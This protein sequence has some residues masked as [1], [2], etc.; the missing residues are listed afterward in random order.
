MN[1]RFMA[2]Q[3]RCATLAQQNQGLITIDSAADVSGFVGSA[4]RRRIAAMI[5]G[6][7]K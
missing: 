6:H 4:L 5:T 1:P 7:D 3:R 2:S